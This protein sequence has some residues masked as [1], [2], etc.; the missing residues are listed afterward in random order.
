M[1]LNSTTITPKLTFA[2][3]IV[4][5]KKS[6][7]IWVV[8]ALKACPEIGLKISPEGDLRNKPKLGDLIETSTKTLITMKRWQRRTFLK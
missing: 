2:C 1:L 8:F 5:H 7:E 3:C 4:L 6:R